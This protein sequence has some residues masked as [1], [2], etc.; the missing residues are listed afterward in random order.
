M[1]T[2]ASLV[3]SLGLE[4]DNGQFTAGTKAI[5]GIATALKAVA[6]FKGVQVFEHWIMQTGEVADAAK[7]MGERMGIS[8]ETVQELTYA[9]KSSDT[10][11][12]ALV[13]GLKRVDR[14]VSGFGGKKGAGATAALKDLGLA[15]KDL[16][17]LTFDEK[18]D[19]L[20]DGFKKLGDQKAIEVANKLGLGTGPLLLLKSGSDK[21]REMRD[22]ARLLGLVID[23]E[24][25]A[26]FEAWNDDIARM[27]GAITGL[28][29]DAVVALLPTLKDLTERL[30]AWIKAN[31]ELIRQRLEV[32][33]KALV[34]IAQGLVKVLGFAYE[35]FE[36]IAPVIDQVIKALG[37]MLHAGSEAGDALMAVAVAVGTAFALANAPI[38]LL[39]AFIAAAV[40]VVNS[41]W[42]AMQGKDSALQELVD[43]FG[44][45]L[46]ESG[47]GR[48]VLALRALFTALF[49][50]IAEK[51]EWLE[52]K[53]RALGKFVHEIV[54][55]DTQFQADEA[56]TGSRLGG[57]SAGYNRQLSAVT[58]GFFSGPAG[59]GIDKVVQA[60]PSARG[61]FDKVVTAADT[62]IDT[63]TQAP[64]LSLYDKA[65]QY[66]AADNATFN[67][68]K[69]QF[70]TPQ[71]SVAA[72]QLHVTVQ[73]SGQA[74]ADLP[75]KIN[76]SIVDMFES[77][78]RDASIATG[79][80]GGKVP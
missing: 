78:L 51:I 41:L 48:A 2:V 57:L 6:V 13:G 15:A 54:H 3:A 46:G 1:A 77:V 74:E 30:F 27:K 63:I 34:N 28:K 21:I 61:S 20:S 56:S 35:M 8:A 44:K 14:L 22:E 17:D 60:D 32:F 7:K 23:N 10:S 70:P 69:F 58:G 16:K 67:A 24:T 71:V 38:I 39:I 68:A 50:Y 26:A 80:R 79:A 64:A 53:G 62:G 75:D 59:T 4:V 12:E 11:L 45:A 18:L 43:A 49:E 5:E 76:E 47:V 65:L 37:E 9:A 66:G 72:P 42:R 31:R 25:A 40:L 52:N 55:G 33:L 29:N 36:K 73:I 19:K